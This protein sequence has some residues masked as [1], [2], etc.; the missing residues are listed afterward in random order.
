MV[1]KRKL[2]TTPHGNNKEGIVGYFEPTWS[3]ESAL[4]SPSLNV[5][6]KLVVVPFPCSLW[7]GYI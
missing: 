5:Y 4:E 6:G 3:W 7:L 1:Y 2:L